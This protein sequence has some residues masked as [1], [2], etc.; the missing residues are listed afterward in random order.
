MAGRRRTAYGL[1]LGLLGGLSFAIVYGLSAE[2]LGLQWGLLV[3]ALVGGWFIGTAVAYGAWAEAEH[4]PVR[5]L[6]IGAVLCG[7]LGWLL[8]L[9]VAYVVSQALIPQA[10]TALL[11]RLS[12]GGYLDYLDGMFDYVRLIHAL[13][14][15]LLAVMAWRAAR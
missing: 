14:V 1:G 15:A 13:A 3:V 2:V 10:A 4:L 7:S 12:L 5:A 9:V 6:R 11:E 8:G